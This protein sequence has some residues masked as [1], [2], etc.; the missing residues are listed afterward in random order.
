MLPE[1]R[2]LDIETFSRIFEGKRIT[3]S[4]KFY[5]FKGILEETKL[6]NTVISFSKLTLS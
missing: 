2:E 4:Y 1:H 5:W 3:N 6:N